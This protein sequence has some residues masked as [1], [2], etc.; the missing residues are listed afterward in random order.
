MTRADM[1]QR[2]MLDE[3]DDSDEIEISEIKGS[4]AAEDVAENHYAEAATDG[5]EGVAAVA[6]ASW[7]DDEEE[8]GDL[9][10]AATM[11]MSRE[12]MIR[13]RALLEAE[14]LDEPAKDEGDGRAKVWKPPTGRRK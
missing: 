8:T 10:A 2:G 9:N 12:E 7:D 14:A 6:E 11:M 1:L 13:R 3:D 5:S 4:G